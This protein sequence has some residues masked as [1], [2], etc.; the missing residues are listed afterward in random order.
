METKEMPPRPLQGTNH[1]REAETMK[2]LVSAYLLGHKVR[3]DGSDKD[4]GDLVLNDL[5]AKGCAVP[6]CPTS[7]ED[8]LCP[9]C[10]RRLSMATRQSDRR[11]GNC[12]RF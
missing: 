11:V 1:H 4:R 12:A 9:A 3:Y 7:R 10:P 2:L 5:V 6:F 8:F